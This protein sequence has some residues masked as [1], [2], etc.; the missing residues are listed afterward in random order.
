ME[1]DFEKS[2]QAE[3]RERPGEEREVKMQQ[4]QAKHPC[5]KP[6]RQKTSLSFPEATCGNADY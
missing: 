1:K 3:R 5:S 4:E 6:C 2:E